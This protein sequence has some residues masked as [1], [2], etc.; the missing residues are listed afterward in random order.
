MRDFSSS[1][2]PRNIYTTEA[3]IS[4]KK[5]ATPDFSIIFASLNFVGRYKQAESIQG[6]PVLVISLFSK[7]R[8]NKAKSQRFKP[9]AD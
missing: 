9:V 3:N 1:Y 2:N 4:I 5:I 6:N 8:K 7:T